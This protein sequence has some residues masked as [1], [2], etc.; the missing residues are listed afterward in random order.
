LALYFNVHRIHIYFTSLLT[1]T[2]GTIMKTRFFSIRAFMMAAGSLLLIGMLLAA[3]NKHDDFPVDNTPVAGIMAFNLASDKDAVGIAI[4]NN[5]LTQAPLKYGDYTGTYLPVYTGQ[6]S[7]GAFNAGAD[8]VFTKTTVALDSGKYYSLFI[9]GAAGTYNNV[10]VKDNFESI[11]ST[12]DQAFV[13]YINAIADSSKPV[14]NIAAGG[15]NVVN[16][17]V[18]FSTVSDF[19]AVT[20]GDVTVG[21]A[22][23]GSINASRAITLEAKKIYTIL[24]TGVPGATDDKKKIQVKFITNGSL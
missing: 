13:R 8:S 18:A 19:V 21:V 23:E 6:R 22:N 20:P 24:L 5:S 2:K 9:V 14:V 17:P 11:P 3:C 1:K 16:T 12:S 15:N 10:F 7:L 4:D